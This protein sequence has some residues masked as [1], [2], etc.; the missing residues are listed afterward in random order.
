M[1]ALNT[2][3]DMYNLLLLAMSLAL[4]LQYKVA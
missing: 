4:L 3:I 2:Q 1:L